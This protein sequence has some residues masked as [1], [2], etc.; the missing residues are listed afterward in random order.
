MKPTPY[1][2]DSHT[3]IYLGDCLEI[4]PHLEP[5]DLV[6]T[7]PPYGI[8]AYSGGTMGGGVLAKQST[9]NPTDWDGTTIDWP[10][11]SLAIAMGKK[12]C[13][14]GGNY[15]PVA[16]SASWLIWDKLN[17]KNNFADCEMAWTNYGGAARLKQHRWHGM[18]RKGQEQRF[19]PTQKPRD[20]MLWCIERCPDNPQTI[21][22]PF[23]GSGTTLVAAKELG[24]KAIGIE[25]SR[26]YCDIAVKR[27]RQEVLF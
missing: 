3:T 20:V 22:D 4:L 14:W 10:T 15:Y 5:V 8:G 27:L 7:D 9:Y 12:A 24:R 16:P 11:I 13:V 21:L 2:Q 17:G 6:L 1:Y 25:I 26:E 18:I 23:M 19:H